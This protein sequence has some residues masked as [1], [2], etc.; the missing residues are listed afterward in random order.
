MSQESEHFPDETQEDK[1][2]T[3]TAGACAD[4]AFML[5]LTIGLCVA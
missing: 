3:E 4:H 1:Q 5:A 2:Q